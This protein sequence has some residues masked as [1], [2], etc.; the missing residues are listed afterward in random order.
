[1]RRREFITLLGGAAARG[2]SRRARSSPSGC[3]ASA[4]SRAMPRTTR[5]T[6]PASR[7]FVQGLA[8]AGMDRGPQYRRS[9]IA[10]PP[11][12]SERIARLREGARSAGAGC[13]LYFRYANIGGSVAGDHDPSRS[14]SR[15]F[16]IRSVRVRRK[17]GRP[18]GHMTGLTNFEPSM[19]GKWLEIAQGDCSRRKPGRA[20]VQSADLSWRRIV[21]F[22]CP[23][24]L[25]RRRSGMQPIA[26]PVHAVGD[27]EAAVEII[28]P[29]SERWSCCPVRQ[30]SMS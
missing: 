21:L 23:S 25:R 7:E 17:P 30:L 26:M 28:H 10:A 18:G 15:R 11:A 29:R 3:G 20:S 12:M 6:G 13:H 27:L 14:S 22:A 4:C 5:S 16:P 2:R 8:S 19:G 9:N 24:R 1:M